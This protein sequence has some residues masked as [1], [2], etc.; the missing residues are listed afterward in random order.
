VKAPI[1]VVPIIELRGFGYFSECSVR[2]A[3][4]L[5][6]NEMLYIRPFKTDVGDPRIRSIKDLAHLKRQ[7]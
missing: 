3:R 5:G 2:L 6:L 7:H 1:Y 4:T